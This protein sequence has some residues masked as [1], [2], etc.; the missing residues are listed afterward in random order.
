MFWRK[1]I[2]IISL[3]LL[4][5]KSVQTSASANFGLFNTKKKKKK[6][7]RE[8]LGESTQAILNS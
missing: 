6:R 1:F 3:D 7:E 8:V 2:H 5:F 4:Y